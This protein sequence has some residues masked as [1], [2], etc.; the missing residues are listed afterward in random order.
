MLY[1]LTAILLLAF[2]AVGALGVTASGPA[3]AAQFCKVGR[4]AYCEKYLNVCKTYGVGT[5]DC[6]AWHS[7]CV[8]CN[9]SGSNCG[10]T[11]TPTSAK[12]E[13][14]ARTFSACMSR[15]YRTFWPKGGG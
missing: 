12:C 11:T 9:E 8:D 6:A 1:R 14:C 15:T 10:L 3:D 7:A 5:R 2:L 4:I 13:S